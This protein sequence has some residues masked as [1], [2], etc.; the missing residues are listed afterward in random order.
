M[1]QKYIEIG[2]TIEQFQYLVGSWAAA[3]VPAV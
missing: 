3:A 2:A 1:V